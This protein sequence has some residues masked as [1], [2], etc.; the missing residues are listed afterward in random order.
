MLFSYDVVGGLEGVGRWLTVWKKFSLCAG[1]LTG[2]WYTPQTDY[3][4]FFSTVTAAETFE[5]IRRDKPNFK[6]TDGL[7]ELIDAVGKPFRDLI[8]D[9]DRWVSRV[10]QTRDNY[11][12][13]PGLRGNPDGEDL[14]WQAELVYTLVV[15]RLLRECGLQGAALPNRDN[16]EPIRRLADQADRSGSG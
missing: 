10:A 16:S 6:L 13:H 8:A 3:C 2:R 4:D 14:Y 12:V 15:L 11:V 1:T 5:R 7:R 9:V